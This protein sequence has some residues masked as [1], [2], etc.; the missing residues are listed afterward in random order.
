[1]TL[2]EIDHGMT[3][4]TDI[5]TNVS[6]KL[7][8]VADLNLALGKKLDRLAEISAA[9]AGLGKNL[10]R[11]AEISTATAGRTAGADCKCGTGCRAEERDS[12]SGP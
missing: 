8:Q 4:V 12:R 3:Q 6:G 5:L 9:T 10:D 1:M 2:Q 11:L 7:H